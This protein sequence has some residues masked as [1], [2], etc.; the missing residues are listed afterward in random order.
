MKEQ[1]VM[2][3]D[4]LR[5]ALSLDAASG[6]LTWKAIGNPQRDAKFAGKLAGG[7]NAQGY[8]TIGL[9]GT[10]L[11]AHRVVFALTHNR[12]PEGQIDHING[13]T[14]D[15][16]PVNLREVSREE[17]QK[18]CRLRADNK[19]GVPGVTL[20]PFTQKWRVRVNIAKKARTVGRFSTKEEAIAFAEE[21]RKEFGYHPN[22]GRYV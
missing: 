19:S 16:R 2:D 17:N 9:L 21:R 6:A 1:I 4:F 18:N 22:H 5:R 11:L 20:D 3:V 10:R 15:N 7:V 8:R 14:L 12:W 13:D